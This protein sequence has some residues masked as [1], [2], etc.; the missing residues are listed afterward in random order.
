[1]QRIDRLL[2]KAKRAAQRKTERFYAGFV[3]HDPDRET[4]TAQGQLWNGR[5]G[6]LRQLVTEHSTMEA[7]TATLEALADEYPN[8]VENTSIFIEDLT[9]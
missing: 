5:P 2:V 4:W 6:G 3:S 1:M 9:E 8:T 7:A